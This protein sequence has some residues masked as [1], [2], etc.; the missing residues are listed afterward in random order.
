MNA[1][2]PPIVDGECTGD[3]LSP[4][5]VRNEE[6]ICR[7]VFESD[8]KKPTEKELAMAV[9]PRRGI[10]DGVI[11]FTQLR[12]SEFSVYRDL[13]KRDETRTEIIEKIK[14]SKP[15]PL[16][17]LLWAAAGAIRGIRGPAEQ[18][19][20]RVFLVLDDV[21]CDRAG[22]KHRLHVNIGYTSEYSALFD[23]SLGNE[24]PPQVHAREKLRLL[25]DE[26]HEAVA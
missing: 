25:L 9:R 17:E 23:A 3:P 6:C 12:K 22:N 4:G 14:S 20:V 5:P 21:V 1:D 10:R 18:P 24:D 15:E 8:Q 19:S 2:V 16:H 13:A 26:G 7:G 11:S